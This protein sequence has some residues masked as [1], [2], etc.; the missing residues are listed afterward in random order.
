MSD[1]RDVTNQPLA[2]QAQEIV[3]A[4]LVAAGAYVDAENEWL[5]FTTLNPQQVTGFIKL[6]VDSGSFYA[7]SGSPFFVSGRQRFTLDTGAG[8]LL[9]RASR[10]E[11]LSTPGRGREY[12]DNGAAFSEVLDSAN[13]SIG[14]AA[15][16]WA[17][18]DENLNWAAGLL[19]TLPAAAFPFGWGAPD[20]NLAGRFYAGEFLISS[21]APATAFQVGIASLLGGSGAPSLTCVSG[22]LTAN[23]GSF[24][25]GDLGTTLVPLTTFGPNDMTMAHVHCRERWTIVIRP[26]AAVATTFSGDIKMIRRGF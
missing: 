24:R 10:E 7:E 23:A 2:V 4:E 25:V 19:N 21:S 1:F 13:F 18:L 3:R 6:F 5:C 12:P 11:L 17:Y 9:Q 8:V 15:G 20:K 26:N 14:F 16:N 22:S